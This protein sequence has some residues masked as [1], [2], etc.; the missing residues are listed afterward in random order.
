MHLVSRC[1]SPVSISTTKGIEQ[2]IARNSIAN[3]LITD[4]KADT[5]RIPLRESVVRRLCFRL[6][7]MEIFSSKRCPAVHSCTF[8]LLHEVDTPC[9]SCTERTLVH[10]ANQGGNLGLPLKV[11]LGRAK[12]PT[13]Q[14]PKELFV[15]EPIWKLK[16]HR[17]Q[18]SFP[19]HRHF[20]PHH[21][22]H[23]Q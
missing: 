5:Q 11:D 13:K 22:G 12:N 7:H 18:I 20:L 6:Y 23:A 21:H 2:N 9:L 1:Q 8:W 19:L 14:T 4:R 17:T 16:P 10:P 15:V 3:G